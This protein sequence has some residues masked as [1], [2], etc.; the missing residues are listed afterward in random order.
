MI[1]LQ[2]PGILYEDLKTIYCFENEI[3]ID[4]IDEDEMKTNP[5]PSKITESGEED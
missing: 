5:N 2:G 3:N 1:G 4:I